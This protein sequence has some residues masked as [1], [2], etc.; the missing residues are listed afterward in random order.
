MQYFPAPQGDENAPLKALI[1]DSYYDNYKGVI[2]FVRI[3]DGRIK[4]GDRI[5]TFRSDKIYD[6]VETGVFSPNLMPQDGLSA[7]RTLRESGKLRK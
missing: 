3:K 2:L 4:A 6:V 5:K 7:A 1:F